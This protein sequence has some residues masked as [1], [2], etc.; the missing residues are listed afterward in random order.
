MENPVRA[1]SHPTPRRRHPLAAVTALLTAPV[2]G[3]AVLVPSASASAPQEVVF[4]TSGT[5]TVPANVTTVDVLV[6]GGGGG[7]SI[8][9]GGGGGE[10]NV[11]SG[12]AVTG[13]QV[14]TATVGAGGGTNAPFVGDAGGTS[15]V[16]GGASPACSATGGAGGKGG[17]GDAAP[18]FY[19][20]GASGNGNL[21]GTTTNSQGGGGGG[22]AGGIG[23]DLVFLVGGPFA[24]AG[25][26]GVTPASL[27]TPGLF[28]DATATFYGGGGG[29]GSAPATPGTGNA[30]AGGAG[31]GGAGEGR[32]PAAPAAGAANTGGG[33]GGGASNAA[34]GVG[35]TGYVV[36]RYEAPPP[37]PDPTPTPAPDPD[38][39]PTPTPT[40]SSTSAPAST[41]PSVLP[42]PLRPLAGTT[43]S[44][45]ATGRVTTVGTLPDGAT[46]VAQSARTGASAAARGL[47]AMG[48][49]R[50]ARATC[51]IEARTY[52]C[53]VVLT[54]GIWT[55]S[56]V[57][58]GPS[59]VVATSTRRVV[60]RGISRAVPVTG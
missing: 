30:G 14:L 15:S 56:T 1:A 54:R 58:S 33:G 31:G 11:C 42:T 52:R 38:P 49:A 5:W 57:A 43:R 59:G 23:E 29:G 3:L 41:S 8:L 45:S 16:A 51:T 19:H 28:A 34:G 27:P 37:T 17:Q 35:G 4:A 48:R 25:G 18:N 6:V 7:S 47:L 22:G 40:G 2:I 32:T 26:T 21:G 55:L 60:V 39:T 9:G 44:A 50:S 20:G 24:G 10:V 53:S 12:I 46:A 36:I 13:S